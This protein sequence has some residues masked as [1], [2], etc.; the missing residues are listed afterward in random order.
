MVAQVNVTNMFNSDRD[1]LARYN[2]TFTGARRIYLRA[3]R[4][5]KFSLSTEF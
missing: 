2:S 1:S 5:W 3:P 4:M